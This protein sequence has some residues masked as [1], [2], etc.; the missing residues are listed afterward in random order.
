[1]RLAI[2]GSR[3]YANEKKIAFLIDKYVEHYGKE[4]LTI[5]S[6]GC[7]DGADFLGKKVALE[8][9]IHYVEFP[10]KHRP[11]NQYCVCSENEYNKPYHVYNYF[12]RNTEIA[13]YC[14]HLAAFTLD[15]VP[16]RGTMDTFGKAVKANKKTLHIKD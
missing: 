8:K 9:G 5:V 6:G 15:G 7:P 14:E 11:H 13:Q 16:C 12:A 1:M 10:P 2:V 3:E 4:N